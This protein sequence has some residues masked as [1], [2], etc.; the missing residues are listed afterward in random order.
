M[1]FA[2]SH[3]ESLE[4]IE[5]RVERLEK[6]HSGS[7]ISYIRLGCGEIRRIRSQ[8]QMT[9]PKG[10]K[11]SIFGEKVGQN[12]FE[13]AGAAANRDDNGLSNITL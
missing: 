9:S 11:T 4:R 2:T 12:R 1:N 5:S 3:F 7:K 8:G 13:P 6:R 10:P